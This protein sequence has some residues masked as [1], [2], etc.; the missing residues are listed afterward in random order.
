MR[1][2]KSILEFLGGLAVSGGFIYSGFYV[3][4][5][6][7]YPVILPPLF[8][9]FIGSWWSGR[10]DGFFRYVFVLF[11]MC[12]GL[13]ALWLTIWLAGKELKR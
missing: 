12:I 10:I 9:A 7:T 5:T 8:D 6:G 3:L 13:G 1:S 4:E 11:F 2:T